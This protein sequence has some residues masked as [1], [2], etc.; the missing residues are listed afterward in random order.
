MQESQNTDGVNNVISKYINTPKIYIILI[1]L[2]ILGPVFEELL[3]RGLLMTSYFKESRFYMDIVLSASVF[4]V[5]H[6]IGFSWGWVEFLYYFLMG[7]LFAIIFR[8]GNSIYYSIIAHIV[9][10]II[11]IYPILAYLLAF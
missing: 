9:W 10:N 2:A 3:C 1:A 8:M 7:A 5:L 4:S 6:L 11:S